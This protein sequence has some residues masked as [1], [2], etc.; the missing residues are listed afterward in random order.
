MTPKVFQALM[1]HGVALEFQ[2]TGTNR[3]H[4]WMSA[5]A[6]LGS[7]ATCPALTLRVKEDM[8][9]TY[10]KIRQDLEFCKKVAAKIGLGFRASCLPVEKPVVGPNEPK[11][12]S[13]VVLEMPAS[14]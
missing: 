10:D 8:S 13:E 3:I 11:I 2:H 7:L 1:G 14:F 9:S 4:G 6:I 5:R 12:E